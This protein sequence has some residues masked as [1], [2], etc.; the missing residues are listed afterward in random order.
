MKGAAL[1]CE[2]RTSRRPA[3]RRRVQNQRQGWAI[4]PAG[5]QSRGKFKEYARNVEASTRLWPVGAGEN[6]SIPECVKPFSWK[7]CLLAMG[8]GLACSQAYFFAAI[9]FL[10]LFSFFY[11]LPA[12]NAHEIFDFSSS[13]LAY[14]IPAL[15]T[16]IVF[17]RRKVGYR[18]V[19]LV[20]LIIAPTLLMSA[21]M[22]L[23]YALA[24]PMACCI[25]LVIGKYAHLSSIR[26]LAVSMFSLVFFLLLVL[27][28]GKSDRDW[29]LEQ[30][31][32]AEMRF[33]SQLRERPKLDMM[34]FKMFP[35]PGGIYARS[36]NNKF[37]ERT[38]NREQ[39]WVWIDSRD[40]RRRAPGGVFAERRL[41]YF[42]DKMPQTPR[43]WSNF[44]KRFN[45]PE[46][47]LTRIMKSKSAQQAD[48][49]VR[50]SDPFV[51]PG[52]LEVTGTW[53]KPLLIF[54]EQ[55]LIIRVGKKPH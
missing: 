49:F 12:N 44:G 19:F 5:F 13:M 52:A 14:S 32:K 41:N 4:L 40:F 6:M 53:G 23:K 21:E 11:S 55:E 35:S 46:E 1:N 27:G 7:T 38:G 36:M 30:T 22:S 10:I 16:S 3:L 51:I 42:T 37:D 15:L 50:S 18:W 2:M 17:E 47:F 20:M 43:E 31:K 8:I 26:G 48:A 9:I 25:G 54:N 39:L 24:I 28:I 29:L 34:D 45:I 33:G